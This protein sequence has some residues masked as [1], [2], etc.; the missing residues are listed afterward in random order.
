MIHYEFSITEASAILMATYLLSAVMGAVRQMLF[1]S[2]FGVSMEANAYYAAFRLPDTLFTLIAGGTLSNAMIPVLLGTRRQEGRAAAQRLVSLVLTTLL[3]TMIV[4]ILLLEIFTPFFV[5]YILAPGFDAETAQ[6]TVTLTRI[7]LLQPLILCVGSVATAVLNSRN[8]FLLPA[9]SILT[10]NISLIAGILAA[11]IYPDLSVYGPT[12]GTVLGAVLQVTLLSP[13][14]AVLRGHPWFTWAPRD[15]HLR[16][17]VSLLI[18]N[19]LSAMVNY[20]GTIVDTAFASL[21]AQLVTLPA[22]YNASLLAN[23]PVTLLGYAVGL[24]AFPRL[25]DRAEAKAWRPLARLLLQV[26]LVVCTLS[27]AAFATIYFAGRDVIR[28]LFERGEFTA[29]AGNATFSAL[30]IYALGLPS[31]IA[32]EIVSRG[33][34]AM[35]DTRTPLFTNAGQLLT[36]TALMAIFVPRIGLYAIPLALVVS[37]TLET[38]V[39]SIILAIKLR[40]RIAQSES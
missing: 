19:G 20:A 40:R 12:V 3:A 33:L 10:Y 13:G 29:V 14:F 15:R 32:T 36:R 2:Q 37:S 18:P 21:T 9:I 11:R 16:E 26:L 30:L 4:I 28:L 25:A 27:L 24:A 35:R 23:L 39:L 5:R 22:I 1:N 8:Q 31:H 34:I 38:I 6:L 7:K 17:V